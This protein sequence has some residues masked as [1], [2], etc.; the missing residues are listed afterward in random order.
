MNRFSRL[1]ATSA[2]VLAA[3]GVASATPIVAGQTVVAA[4]VTYQVSAPLAFVYP[5]AAFTSQAPAGQ[6]SSFSGTY[7]TAVT[8]DSSNNL[9]N[10][11]GNCLTFIIQVS[12]N[13]TSRDP[14]ETV[15]TAIFGSGFTYNV[16]YGTSSGTVAP[17]YIALN[18]AGIFSFNFTQPGATTTAIQPGQTSNYLVI[19]TSA[20]AYTNGSI[21]FQD[22][23]TATVAGFMPT[24]AAVTVTPEPSSL[25]LLGTGLIGTATTLLRR[26]KLV[27]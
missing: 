1:F 22:G 13:S 20:T 23:Q 6:T 25:V 2:L 15:T 14:I 27:A 18:S 26:R 4:P 9:C 7:G 24:A 11:A 10:S 19:Q 17:L 5:A 3:C 16:G 12:N 8:K 21:S